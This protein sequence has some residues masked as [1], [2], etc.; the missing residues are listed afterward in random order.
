[1][2][3]VIL[4]GASGMVGQG[5]LREC[6]LDPRV[7]AV[8]SVARGASATRD[9]KFSE[10]VLRDFHDYSEI[11]G[12]LAGYDAAFFCLGVSA[13][14]MSEQDYRRITYGIAMAAGETLVRLNPGMTFIYVSGQGTDANGRAMWARVKGETENALLALP[15]KAAFM[16]RPGFI[17]PMH[18]IRSR[19]AVYNAMYTI[20]R[21]ILPILR[22]IFRGSI[23]TTEEIGRAMIE[24]AEA[25]APK[26]VL[27]ARDIIAMG[28]R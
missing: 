11:E 6:L 7:D 13:V 10:I 27:E 1:M 5:V 8:L 26:R 24:V 18:G 20:A 9:A 16:F 23:L 15:F 19:T 4:F 25:G 17:E 2:M 3:R 14:G 22:T 28:R 12:Q 21:P